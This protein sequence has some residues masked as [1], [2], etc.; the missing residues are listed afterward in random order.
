MFL[1][2]EQISEFTGCATCAAQ[3]LWLN[4]NNI[5]HWV[6]A[7]GHPIVSKNVLDGFN[8]KTAQT[9][10]PTIKELADEGAFI[11]SKRTSGI[12]FLSKI[13]DDEIREIVYVGQT[14]DLLQ[15]LG[16]H[17]IT[18]WD[19]FLFIEVEPSLLDVME[20]EYIARINPKYNVQ[21]RSNLFPNFS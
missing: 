6:D 20:Q 2:H 21:F 17:N 15:R 1:T 4:A 18:D 13:L 7:N 14:V 9:P 8:K 16:K 10:F 5:K 12:Y 3:I 19:E 11:F